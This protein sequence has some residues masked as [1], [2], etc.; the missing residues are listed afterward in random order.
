ML[1]NY[2]VEPPAE[3]ASS[4]FPWV[5]SEKA[6]LDDRHARQGKPAQDEALS[7][8]LSLLQFLRRVLLQDAAVLSFKYPGLPIFD[9]HP[10]NTDCFRRFAL[11]SSAAIQRAEEDARLKLERLPETIAVSMRGALQTA[12]LQQEQQN[13]HLQS[14]IKKFYAHFDRMHT[15]LEASLVQ[16]VKN[17]KKRKALRETLDISSCE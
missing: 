5:E 2:F 4:I 15:V 6:A 7:K 11:S 14:E 13:S 8:F 17:P 12:T 16:N 1:N 3:L 10:F 9:S